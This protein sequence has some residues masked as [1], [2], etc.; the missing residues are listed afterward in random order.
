LARGPRLRLSAEVIRDCALDYAG[1]LD[2]NRAP[3][4]PSVKP[5]QPAGLWE[6]K[7]FGGNT[8]TESKGEDLYRRSLYTLWKRTVLNPTLMTFDAPDRAIC[9]EQRSVTCTPLQAFVTLN[10][11]GFVEA[12]RVMAARILQEGGPD[13]NQRINFAYKTVLARPPTPRERKIL[14]DVHADMV[15]NYQHDLKGAVDLLTTGDAKRP[16][17]LDELDLVGWT[18]VAN[19]LLNLDETITKE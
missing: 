5:Y 8:Y 4:G 2:R 12:A 11:K 18:G 1:L 3:G 6:E 9:T 14:A 7:M 10:E 13:L 16:E 15:A 19:V 17:K